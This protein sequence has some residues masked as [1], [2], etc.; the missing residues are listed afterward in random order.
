MTTE[1]Y[2]SLQPFED[3]LLCAYQQQFV[4]GVEQ[5]Q[6]NL[7]KTIYLDITKCYDE[8]R[9]NCSSCVIR[10]YSEVGRLYI[11][12]KD[13][14]IKTTTIDDNRST[15]LTNLANSTNVITKSKGRP[16]KTI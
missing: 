13:S 11:Q 9:L 12:H 6:F 8:Y 5:E 16:K 10:L 15:I 7:I 4:R 3:I 14:L 1:Q 2:E